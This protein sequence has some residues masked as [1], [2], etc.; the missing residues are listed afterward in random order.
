MRVFAYIIRTVAAG[1]RLTGSVPW[2]GH[3]R[4]LFG[5]C[6]KR[7]RPEVVPGDYILGISGAG[8]GTPRR[9][10]LWM[11]VREKI[12]FAE[13]YRRGRTDHV[14]RAARGC[15]IHV[16]PRAGAAFLPGWPSS[17]EHI[18]GAPHLE[19]WR[20]DIR[21]ERDAFLV[22]DVRSWVA[23]DDGPEVTMDLVSLLRAGVTW[24]GEP[25]LENPLTKNARGKHAVVE[26]AA[27]R[28]II[29]LMRPKRMRS[30][31]SSSRAFNA[32]HGRCGCP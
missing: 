31:E 25:T 29:D 23:G 2:C 8:G 26:G 11:R 4:V 14:F 13:A 1:H 7:M 17:Y 21:G 19:G 24:K 16:R 9:V 32:C 15:A 22:G 5:P 12:S 27:A 20:N 18:P 3:G 30:T 10:L 6:K 28:R